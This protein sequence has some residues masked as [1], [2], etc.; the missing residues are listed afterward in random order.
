MGLDFD[1]TGGGETF[2]DCG[3]EG[4]GAFEEGPARLVVST[5]AEMLTGPVFAFLPKAM[6]RPKASMMIHE[7]DLEAG[8]KEW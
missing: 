1:S 8:L 2:V 3:R 4:G 6:G 5:L 7:L